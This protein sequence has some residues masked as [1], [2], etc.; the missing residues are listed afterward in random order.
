MQGQVFQLI[1]FDVF[2]Y[3]MLFIA[4]TAISLYLLIRWGSEYYVVTHDHVIH[5]SGIIVKR[6]Q[7]Y[8]LENAEVIKYTKGFLG[9]LLGYG[10]IEIVYP[11]NKMGFCMKSIANPEQF[12]FLIE[13]RKK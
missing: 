5:K 3:L 12:I 10:D 4:Q 8:A 13:S 11:S 6:E 1:D 2:V 9:R 7:R